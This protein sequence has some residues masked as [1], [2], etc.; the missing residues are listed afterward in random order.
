[1]INF[2]RIKFHF[3]HVAFANDATFQMGC[4][5]E[6]GIV[7]QMLTNALDVCSE[8]PVANGHSCDLDGSLIL[9]PMGLIIKDGDANSLL[10]AAQDAFGKHNVYIKDTGALTEYG[11]TTMLSQDFI[12]GGRPNTH[13]DEDGRISHITTPKPWIS[14]PYLTVVP[15]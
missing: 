14:I 6:I 15:K 10:R 12:I 5:P 1:M 3:P 4:P 7:D 9:V 13:E 8:L 11:G 2:T